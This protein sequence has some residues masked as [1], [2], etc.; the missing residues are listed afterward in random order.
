MPGPTPS[1]ADALF[2]RSGRAAGA[3]P[4]PQRQAA[5]A[6]EDVPVRRET[7]AEQMQKAS[8]RALSELPVVDVYHS[9]GVG[10]VLCALLQLTRRSLWLTCYCFDLPAGAAV[11]ANLLG[12]GVEVRLLI[13]K[14]QMKNPSCTSQHETIVK[15]FGVAGAQHLQVRAYSPGTGAFSALHAKTWCADGEVYFGGSFN[16]TRNAATH[17]EEHLVVV[18]KPEAVRVQ[19]GWFQDLWDKAD[20]Q[21]VEDVAVLMEKLK[22]QKEAKK[23][24]SRS[25][26][27]QRQPRRQGSAA[28]LDGSSA[29][30][31][32]LRALPAV[33]ESPLASPGRS[34]RAAGEGAVS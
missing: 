20:V 23:G 24:P 6:L 10:D 16:F 32:E 33:S 12:R 9:P 30:A 27:A 34:P 18:R 8:V 29:G 25:L 28:L 13:C 11:L 1:A 21:T 3:S 14:S 22:A 7:A 26:S 15:L 4:S 31:D 2:G 19:E 5:P 17:N